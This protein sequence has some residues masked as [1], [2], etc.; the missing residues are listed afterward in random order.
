[1]KPVHLEQFSKILGGAKSSI[2]SEANGDDLSGYLT[3]WTG[4]FTSKSGLSSEPTDFTVLR[5]DSTEK[6]SYILK[7]CNE[8]K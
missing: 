3:D 6:V 4:K 1:L 2:L 5:P 8:N 7:F